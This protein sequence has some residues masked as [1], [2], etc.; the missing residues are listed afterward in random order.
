MYDGKTLIEKGPAP[1]FYR[2]LVE[3]DKNSFDGNWN[4]V[5][6]NTQVESIDTA[7][8]EAGQNVITANIVFNLHPFYICQVT[9]IIHF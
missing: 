7:V 2:G 4:G 5:E 6:K 3:N 1:N 9:C 8:N